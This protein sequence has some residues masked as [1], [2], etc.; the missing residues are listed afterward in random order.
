LIHKWVGLVMMVGFAIHTVYLLTR[1][2]WR[3]PMKSIFGEDSLLPNLSDL[4]HF[5]QRSPKGSHGG[6]AGMGGEPA[7]HWQTE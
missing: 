5:G 4:K 7:E 6:K 1:I 2:N 3:T